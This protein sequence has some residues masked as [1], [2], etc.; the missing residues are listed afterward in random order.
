MS[1][2]SPHDSYRAWGAYRQERELI[3]DFKNEVAEAANV[4]NVFIIINEW[5]DITDNSG[6]EVVGGVYFESEN[7]AWEALL[8]I[9]Q[10]HDTTLFVD[11]TSF[12]LED[13]VSNLQFEEYYIQELSKNGN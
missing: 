2:R 13:H 4:S 5:T 11:E 8:V 6:S 9:A 12:S 10:S 3:K 1:R 7:D